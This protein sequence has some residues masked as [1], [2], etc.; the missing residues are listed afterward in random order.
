MQPVMKYCLLF[1]LVY[2]LNHINTTA[3][4]TTTYADSIINKAFYKHN[5]QYFL[6]HYGKDDSTK[7]II[8]GFF[9]KRRI[10]IYET[11]IPIA[12]AGVSGIFI[13]KLG[14]QTNVKA[15]VG[16]TGFLVVISL[17]LVIYAAPVYI[18]DGQIKLL[19]FNRKKL[20]TLLTNYNSGKPLPERLKHKK[21][22]KYELEKLQ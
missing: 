19:V 6:D 20:L 5:R 10:A 18:I 17:A 12:A 15:D 9:S 14:N 3:A 13:S 4:I 2:F 11:V 8:N 1:L 22:F 7:A 16:G 21:W